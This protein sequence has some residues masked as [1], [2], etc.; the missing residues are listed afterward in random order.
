MAVASHLCDISSNMKVRTLLF[1]SALTLVACDKADNSEKPADAPAK[2]E[3]KA[4]DN[5]A[6][7]KKA[8]AH[9]AYTDFTPDQVEKMLADKSCV[10]VDTNSEATRKKHGMVP[11]AVQLTSYNEYKANELPDD[12]ATKLVFYCGGKKCSA[13]PKAAKLAVDAGYKD[14]NVMRDGIKG[15]VAAGKKVNKPEA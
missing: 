2:T 13:A 3:A 6:D 4:D 7:E 8:D 9:N 5:K 1:L 11:G 12:K 10:V 15:W 14:V